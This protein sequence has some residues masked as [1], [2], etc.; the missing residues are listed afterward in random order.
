MVYIH[1]NSHDTALSDLLKQSI[2]SSHLE[3]GNSEFDG[4]RS[5]VNL[6]L[7]L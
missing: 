5:L 6:S 7:A 4:N 2:S 1:D 3:Q